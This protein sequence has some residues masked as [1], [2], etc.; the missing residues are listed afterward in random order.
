[1]DVLIE[2]FSERDGVPSYYLRLLE[3]I[4][5]TDGGTEAVVIESNGAGLPPAAAYV[6]DRQGRLLASQR[7]PFCGSQTPP[8]VASHVKPLAERPLPYAAQGIA[9]L[10]LIPRARLVIV[11]GGHVGKAVADLAAD[12]DF[13]VWVVDDRP[14]FVAVDRFPRAERRI[15]GPIAETLAAL[16]ITTNTYCLIV[17]RGHQHDEQA[18]FHLVDRKAAYVGMIGSR[19]KI[20]LIYEDLLDQ[21]I[22]AELL[23]QVHAPVGVDIGSRT[24][25]EIA[26]SIAAELISFRNRLGRIPGRSSPSS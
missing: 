5:S 17:T 13:D 9:Y 7:D 4:D 22:R 18:L 25:P 1:M 11:G 26:V 14:Q 2:P 15:A 16:D 12:L 19:R 3:L 20:R 10:P 23:E 6:L 8:A 21:G 24:V